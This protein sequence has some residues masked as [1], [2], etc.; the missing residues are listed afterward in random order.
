M[1]PPL[2]TVGAEYT[3]KDNGVHVIVTAVRHG[4][5][6]WQSLRTRGNLPV[7]VFDRKFQA[8]AP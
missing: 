7:H 1:N 8:V 2:P 3:R 6:H 4:L 5:V